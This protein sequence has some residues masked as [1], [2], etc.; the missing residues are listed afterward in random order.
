MKKIVALP[1]LAALALSVTACAKTAPSDNVS[2]TTLNETITENASASDE[3]GGGN[4]A[5]GNVS[6]LET[7]SNATAVTTNAL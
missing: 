7:T 2:E 6:D 5:K 1:L 3:L 4:A